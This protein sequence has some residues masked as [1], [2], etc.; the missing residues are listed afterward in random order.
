MVQDAEPLFDLSHPQTM[1]GR[2][3]DHKPWVMRY[4]S[5]DFFAMMRA[6][7]ITSKMNRA[8]GFGNL[9]GQ[10][11]PKGDAFGRLWSSHSP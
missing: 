4:P 3:V 1:N 5:G 10:V 11:F 6:D 2:E 7:M 9:P 8:D